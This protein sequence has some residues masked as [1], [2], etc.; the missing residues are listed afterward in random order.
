MIEI[1]DKGWCMENLTRL[2]QY[3]PFMMLTTDGIKPNKNRI[4][5][6][7]ITAAIVGMVVSFITVREMKASFTTEFQNI[8]YR[9]G[10]V[11][12]LSETVMR[13]EN[14]I[15]IVEDRQSERLLRERSK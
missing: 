3:M 8:Y 6:A 7:L 11:E 1:T 4:V 9:L 15:G 13:H 12:K 10:C 2:L 5:E 14:R